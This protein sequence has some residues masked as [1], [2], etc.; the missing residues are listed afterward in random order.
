MDYNCKRNKE[1][2]NNKIKQIALNINL[3]GNQKERKRQ[4]NKGKK[5]IEKCRKMKYMR[6]RKKDER[7]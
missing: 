4:A 5:S 1:R 6:K 2:T 7:K 3:K